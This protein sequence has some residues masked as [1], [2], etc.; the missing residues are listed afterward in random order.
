MYIVHTDIYTYIYICICT[1][2]Y[3]HTGP[4]AET[5]LLDKIGT[6]DTKRKKKQVALQIY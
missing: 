2:I 1:Y 6:R 3:T 5:T 4:L